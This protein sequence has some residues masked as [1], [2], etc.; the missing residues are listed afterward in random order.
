VHVLPAA[1]C[2]SSTLS[3]MGLYLRHVPESSCHSQLPR[4]GDAARDAPVLVGSHGGEDGGDA[5]CDTPILD[6]GDAA[7]DTP[8]LGR[9]DA[10]RDTPTVEICETGD[11]RRFSADASSPGSK[12]SVIGLG[13]SVIFCRISWVLSAAVNAA[14]DS[15]PTCVNSR[16][17]TISLRMC[18]DAALPR[19]ISTSSSVCLP[20]GWRFT[21]HTMPSGEGSVNATST[22][23]GL[24]FRRGE[25]ARER[26]M[27]GRGD[28]ARDTPV[29]WRGE[30]A[31]D[32]SQALSVT[33]WRGDAAR[34]T[35]RLLW[36]RGI[37]KPVG[38]LL[39][40][41]VL[42]TRGGGSRLVS[43]LRPDSDFTRHGSGLLRANAAT[44]RSS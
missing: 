2:S 16:P 17:A 35:G 32:R 43:W 24:S 37:L 23:P 8:M 18:L 22:A 36:D 40:G 14:I 10:A 30:P 5:A 28:A 21:L 39:A 15:P 38:V 13:Q 9:G 31:R 27:L 25:A 11:S 29:C 34:G 6:R 4:R 41:C 19:L 42:L 12:V 20:S 26:P 44:T 3:R 7:R 1:N 33:L